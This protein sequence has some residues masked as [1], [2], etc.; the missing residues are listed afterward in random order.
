MSR[1]PAEFA[2]LLGRFGES[3][4]DLQPELQDLA[5]QIVDDLRAGIR[6]QGLIDTGA[7]I[8]SV[9]A[10]ATSN[11]LEISMLD[12]GMY[13]NYGVNGTSG[14]KNGIVRRVEFGVAPPPR[15]GEFYSFRS[16]EFGIR[17]RQFFTMENLNAQ[18]A[19]E[20]TITITG[21]FN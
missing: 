12:Y 20:I 2:A 14:V 9:R 8:G 21:I 1:T 19:D 17:S 15:S 10:Q 16:R 7:L 6:S 11:T 4:N 18:L 3:L 5:S 13:N